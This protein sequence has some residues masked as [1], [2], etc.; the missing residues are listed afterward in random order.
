MDIAKRRSKLM[1]MGVE[2]AEMFIFDASPSR[3]LLIVRR[4]G[5]EKIEKLLGIQY[6]YVSITE[7]TYPTGSNP[8][9]ANV[10]V[11]LTGKDKEGNVS[12]A[13]GSANPDTTSV[14]FFSD[15]ANKR[16]RHKIV[17]MLAD[18]YQFD[19]HSEEESEQFKPSKQFNSEDAVKEAIKKVSV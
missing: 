9:G 16:A 11:V 6:T 18:L 2:P 5:I 8:A 15:M 12:Q 7:S 19:V 4:T 14:K 13:L 1:N 3:Q 17:L 10:T